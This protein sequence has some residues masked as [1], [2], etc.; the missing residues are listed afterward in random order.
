MYG[1]AIEMATRLV[2]VTSRPCTLLKSSSVLMKV[3]M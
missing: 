3:G 2:A 1:M